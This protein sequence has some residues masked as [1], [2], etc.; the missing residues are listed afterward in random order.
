MADLVL[1]H[2]HEGAYPQHYLEAHAVKFIAHCLWIREP[3]GMEIPFA[4]VFLPGVVYHDDAGGE[5]VLKDSAGV[6]EYSFLV[7]VVHKFYPGVVLGNPV[8]F[9]RREFSGGGEMCRRSGFECIREAVSGFFHRDVPFSDDNCFVRD[10]EAERGVTP[11]ISAIR[12]KKKRGHL[13]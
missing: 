3:A 12:G 2:A 10:A 13:I 9:C 6:I 8:E 1:V 5:A 4:V 11:D 7:L